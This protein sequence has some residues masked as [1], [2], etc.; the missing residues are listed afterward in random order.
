MTG[1]AGPRQW[2]PSPFEID[3][4][5]SSSN[6][7]KSPRSSTTILYRKTLYRLASPAPIGRAEISL[8]REI[9][10]LLRVSLDDFFRF[11]PSLP[12]GEPDERIRRTSEL[13]EKNNQGTITRSEWR[14]LAEL[15]AEYEA[16]VLNN[17]QVR[18]WRERPERFTSAHTLAPDI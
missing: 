14:E 2:Y 9:C 4:N 16:A 8:I 17:A 13:A 18:L 5:G 12:S 7:I 3:L 15:V 10:D 1:G 6:Y 11:A